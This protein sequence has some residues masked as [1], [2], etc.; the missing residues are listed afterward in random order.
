MP[1]SNGV[2]VGVVARSDFEGASAELAVDVVVGDDGNGAVHGRNLDALP[3]E[4]LEPAVL[5]V[6]A[7]G[8]VA[9]DSFGSGRSHGQELVAPLEDVLEVVELSHL[10]SEPRSEPRSEGTSKNISSAEV[11]DVMLGYTLTSSE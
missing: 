5:R 2:I 7:D 1:L 11:P 9:P 4:V 10:R 6:D 3:D 8:G